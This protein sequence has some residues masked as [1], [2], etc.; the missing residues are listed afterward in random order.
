M[1]IMKRDMSV[2]QGHHRLAAQISLCPNFKEFELKVIV[3][4][5]DGKRVNAI[6]FFDKAL[7]RLG[8]KDA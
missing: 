7:N 6:L 4:E 1:I 5:E 3:E 8:L 2:I